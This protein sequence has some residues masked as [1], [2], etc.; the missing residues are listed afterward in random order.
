MENVAWAPALLALGAGL[1][2]G[3]ALAW[4][5]RATRTVPPAEEA[6]AAARRDLEAHRDTLLDQ[7]RE[8]EDIGGGRDP[9]LLA[10][11]RERLELRAAGVLA[12]LDKQKPAAKARAAQPA[13]AAAP[14]AVP[15]AAEARRAARRGFAWGIGSAVAIGGLMLWVS[16]AVK[17]RGA[18][19]QLTGE[20]PARS[21]PM[22]A[23][24][25]AEEAGPDPELA[26]LEQVVAS[27]PD[28]LDARMELTQAYLGRSELM[29]VWEQTK[30]VL[31]RSPGHPR[32]MSYQALVRLA[33]GQA[34][35][36][37]QQLKQA[38]AAAPDLLEPR[39][40]LTLVYLRTGRAK[41]A[42]AVLDE[43]ERRFPTQKAGLERL[44][45]EMMAAQAQA[46][47]EA[48]AQGGGG[49]DHPPA[50]AAASGP[51]VS[52]QI[53]LDPARGAAPAGAIVF[54]TARAAGQTEGPPVA[55]KRLPAAFPLQ[56]TLGSEDS[57]MGQELP[58]QLRVEARLDSDGDPL[59]R[60]PSDPSA[61]LDGVR[62][63]QDGLRLH[64]R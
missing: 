7:L 52:G 16:G 11:E 17:P 18:N 36:A 31:K 42:N 10:R 15:T 37:E 48:V 61:R 56:F 53:D 21:G 47:A 32:A 24:A 14:P 49:I 9:V 30:E 41:E 1:A 26:R 38:M 54:V 63:G 39:L 46:D 29:Q 40:H 3:A 20:L 12:E 33:M 6:A 13:A 43:A 55:V 28:D 44:R 27:N 45:R 8:L 25:Q 34:D 22:G 62:L 51:R 58:P 50:G 64:L 35:A 60:P 23:P 57:M 4:L 5:L 59:T 2:G 19:G